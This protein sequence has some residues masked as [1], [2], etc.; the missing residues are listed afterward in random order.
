MFF[1]GGCP[2]PL[3][4][5]SPNPQPHGVFYPGKHP[6]GDAI[7]RKFAGKDASKVRPAFMV[8]K[9]IHG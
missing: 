2:I 9:V 3:S 4:T 7:L 6:G 5:P 8:E 1:L